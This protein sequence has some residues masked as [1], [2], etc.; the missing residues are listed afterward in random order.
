M[1]PVPRTRTASGQRSFAATWNRLPPAL[2]SPDLSESA[3]KRAPK[4][5]LFSTA[6]YHWDSGAGYKYP[7]SLTCLLGL[8]Q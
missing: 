1:V 2:Q 6:R 5:H 7:E 4:T 3:F 8:C